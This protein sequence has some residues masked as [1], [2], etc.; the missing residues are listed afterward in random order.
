[1]Y[2]SI[3]FIFLLMILIWL[4]KIETCKMLRQKVVKITLYSNATATTIRLTNN[5]Y[6]CKIILPE[7]TVCI[8]FYGN[9]AFVK[10]YLHCTQ[11]DKFKQRVQPLSIKLLQ[12]TITTVWPW[13]KACSFKS[14]RWG[15]Q[16]VILLILN[17]Y[18]SV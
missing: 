16:D 2:I 10:Q 5:R 15:K 8:V 3:I 7:E 11:P 4:S 17:V 12:Y 6:Q 13:T 1:M 9:L 14:R 18:I